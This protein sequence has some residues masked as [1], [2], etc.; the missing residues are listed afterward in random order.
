MHINFSNTGSPVLC[1]E[2]TISRH[3][4]FLRIYLKY[5]PAFVFKYNCEFSMTPCKSI[6]YDWYVVFNWNILLLK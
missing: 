4:E 5:Y 2:V 6:F 1:A 3:F